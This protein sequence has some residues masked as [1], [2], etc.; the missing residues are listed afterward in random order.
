MHL[1]DPKTGK[2]IREN[3]QL[4]Y[5]SEIIAAFGNKKG[6]VLF[7]YTDRRILIVDTKELKIIYFGHIEG[8]GSIFCAYF[9]ENYITLCSAK[10]YLMTI[11]CL[12]AEKL[13]EVLVS[14]KE[15]LEEAYTVT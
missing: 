13:P 6:F 15:I 10:N 14:D 11:N 9:Y 12:K 8:S 4:P 7:I 1:L 5:V 2:D 3:I